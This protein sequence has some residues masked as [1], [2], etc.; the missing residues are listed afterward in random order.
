MKMH[1]FYAPLPT[2]GSLEVT[3][4]AIAHQVA[5]VLKL[6]PPER[7]V[8]FDGSGEEVIVELTDVSAK[9]LLGTVIERRANMSESPRP[10]TLYCAMV[11]RASFEWAIEKAT[12]AGATRIVPVIT[13]RTV[14][15]GVKQERLE[16]IAREAA[17][18]CGRGR[19][20]EIAEPLSLARAF[21]E[22]GRQGDVIVFDMGGAV[23]V[24]RT[25]S[26]PVALF[27]GPEGG[28]DDADRVAFPEKK[29]VVTLGPRVLRAETAAAIATF[30]AAS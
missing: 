21:A 27:V 19:V 18:Q 23:W 17:E 30:L 5:T 12:E 7:I 29:E 3:E 13:A 10:V 22:A 11:K 9:A 24:P 8:L 1:R 28:W 2:G 26:R 15:L 16:T 20:P 6:R 4:R 14:K 25:T